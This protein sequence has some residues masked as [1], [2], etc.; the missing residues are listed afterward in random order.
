MHRYKRPLRTALLA[1]GSAIALHGSLAQAVLINT[2]TGSENTSAPSGFS[3]WANVGSYYGA[4]AV[5]LGDGWVLTAN[6]VD[7][8]AAS[9]TVNFSSTNYSILAGTRQRLK[10]DDNTDTDLVVFKIASPPALSALA[11]STAAPSASTPVL[12]IGN[13]RNRLTTVPNPSGITYWDVTFTPPSTY[14]WTETTNTS[15]ADA[16]GYKWAGSGTKRWGVN[17]TIDLDPG[18]GITTVINGGH[19]DVSVFATQFNDGAYLYEAQAAAGDS[20]GGVFDLSGQLLGIM[21]NIGGYSGQPGETAV[22][23]NRTY[24]A[25]IADYY[26]QIFAATGVP[27][28]ASSGLFLVGAMGFFARRH[29]V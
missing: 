6:H 29:R 25:N 20:G 3:Q 18:A 26:D 24:A 28:P 23:G 7:P 12:M 11:L 15:I 14:T 27:E 10:N 5:Y 17:D 8:S 2:A 19:G 13:G 16:A 9:S 21:T 22:F 4:S 1:M